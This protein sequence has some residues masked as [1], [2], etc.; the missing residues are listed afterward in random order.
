MTNKDGD[1]YWSEKIS[2]PKCQA[3]MEQFKLD[4][5]ELDRCPSCQ[6]LWFDARELKL[7]RNKT[8]ARLVDTGSPA[9]G[10]YMNSTDG[11]DCPRCDGNM[12]RLVDPGQPHIWYETCSACHGSFLDAGELVDLTDYSVKDL[13]KRLTTPER[14]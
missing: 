9:V 6:G 10:Q 1:R 13:F 8:S 5:V 12:L 11:Y 2:C 4:L 14:R 7:L 3:P